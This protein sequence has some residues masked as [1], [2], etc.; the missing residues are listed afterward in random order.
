MSATT[1]TM[2][3]IINDDYYQKRIHQVVYFREISRLGLKIRQSSHYQFDIE[4]YI[5]DN[6]HRR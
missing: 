5:F 4:F 6:P 1:T 2:I 3:T